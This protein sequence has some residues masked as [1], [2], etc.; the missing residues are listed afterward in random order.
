M[1]TTR[2][3]CSVGPSDNGDLEGAPMPV[4]HQAKRNGATQTSGEGMRKRNNKKVY[5]NMRDAMELGGQFSK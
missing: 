1:T 4:W 5:I 2:Y 3:N